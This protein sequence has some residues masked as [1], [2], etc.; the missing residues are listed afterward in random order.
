MMAILMVLC[1]T[2][3]A[4]AVGSLVGYYEAG[5]ADFSSGNLS[6]EAYYEGSTKYID[7]PLTSSN[8]LTGTGITGDSLVNGR[9]YQVLSGVYSLT[10]TSSGSKIYNLSLT[11]GSNTVKVTRDSIYPGSYFSA[12]AT[13]LQID[14]NTHTI[15]WSDLSSVS[16]NNTISSTT[17]TNLQTLATQYQ[18]TSFNFQTLTN[19]SNW[20]KG[21]DTDSKNTPYYAK[22]EGFAP[23]PGEWALILIGLT[24]LGFYLHR[25]GYLNFELSPQATA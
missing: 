25:R 16:F 15:S 18:F 11:E 24:M 3:I 1:M 17:L 10:E 14:F 13:A 8:R 2:G 23:E 4:G 22:M 7:F 19:E 20:L 21:T 6:L 12:L 5:K 9:I